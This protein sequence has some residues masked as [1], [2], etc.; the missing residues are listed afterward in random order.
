LEKISNYLLIMGKNKKPKHILTYSPGPGLNVRLRGKKL[1][2][3][4]I[5][6]Y[7][8][9][10]QGFSKDVETNKIK[11]SRKVE[12]L[13]LYLKANPQRAEDREKNN[14]ILDL[15]QSIRSKR[16][17]D[18][19]HNEE[20]FVSPEKRKVNMF[21]YF[22]SYSDKYS[23]NDIRMISGAVR[24][25]KEFTK[26]TF[27][28]PSQITPT[29]IHE[30]ADYLKG[31]FKG[32]GPRSYFARFKKIL[33]A[34]S[35]EGYFE[36]SP[37]DGIKCGKSDKTTISKEILLIEDVVKLHKMEASNPEIKRAFMFCLNTGLRFVDVND[38]QYMHINKR[39]LTKEQIK[40]GHEV[41]VD[42]NDKA[43]D[44]IGEGG[45]LEDFVFD[46]PSNTT[47]LKVLKAWAKSAGIDRNITWHSARHSFATMLLINKTDIKTVSSLLG[48]S[49]LEHTQKYLH[50][51]DE[52]KKK[53]VNTIQ[54]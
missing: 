51:V 8:D 10:Y 20:G 47:C 33:T 36:R 46:L 32:E 5:S 41:K 48:H 12:Y 6:L 26:E 42:L 39:V 30:Y 16:E 3:G 44:L 49:K 4:K 43:Y 27:L 54:Y 18:L 19:K 15:A 22:Q 11:I 52:L 29:L 2:K 23:K 45:G 9:Y 7:L 13:K 24:H 34:A 14:E 28:K 17:S 53:A 37:A 31:K 21:D 40:T 35:N 25:F 50:V 1:A 38:L